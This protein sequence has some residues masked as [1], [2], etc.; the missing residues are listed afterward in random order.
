MYTSVSTLYYNFEKRKGERARFREYETKSCVYNQNKENSYRF[1]PAG[2]GCDE[3]V[4][5]LI[6]TNGCVVSK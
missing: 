4:K 6:F 2:M 1:S 3:P 5:S